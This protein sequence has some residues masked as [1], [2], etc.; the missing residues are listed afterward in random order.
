MILTSIFFMGNNVSVRKINYEDM[1]KACKKTDDENHILIN[2]MDNNYQKCLINNTIEI[3]QEEKIINS[4][5]ENGNKNKSIIIYGKNSNDESIVKKYEQLISLGF[6]N[7]TIY[8]G[9]MF[10][11][12]L[13]QDVY[14][15]ELFPTTSRELDI[16]KYKPPQKLNIRLISN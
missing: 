4:L 10:E 2:T 14:G 9:G 13:L 1:Q 15:K 16:L 7:I 3:D 12:L 8:T 6:T 5:L 11:W